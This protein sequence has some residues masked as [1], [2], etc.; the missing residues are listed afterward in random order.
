V[1]EFI[2]P[3]KFGHYERGGGRADGLP[4]QY[5]LAMIGV[6]PWDTLA[7]VGIMP[8]TRARPVPTCSRNGVPGI[9]RRQWLQTSCGLL[10]LP[11]S[12]FLGLRAAGEPP[13][14]SPGGRAKAC[15]IVYC[16]GG[17]SHLDTL[18]LKPDA[19]AEIR[20][21]FRP[22]ATRV[23]GIRISEHLPLLARHADKLALI[24]SIHHRSTAHGKGMYWNL[25]GHAPAQAEAAV[26]QP[27]SREDWPCLAAMIGQFR[28][29]ARGLPHAVQLP[30]PLVDNNTLQAGENAGWL[31]VAAD[32]VIVRTPRG[33]AFGGVS[34]DLGAPVLNLSSQDTDALQ[35]RR[36]LLARLDA[37][38]VRSPAEANLDHYRALA[39]DMLLNPAVRR[40]FDLD[41]EPPRLRDAYGDHLGGQ[42]LLLARRLVEAGVPVVTVICAAGD[43]NGSAGDHWDTHSD[44]FNRLK[45]T[46]LPVLDRGVAALLD[47]LH[48]RGRLEETL[49]VILG[50]F[51][52][53]PKVNGSAGRDHYPYAFSVALA[54]GG[55]R[56]GQVY[57]STDRHGAFPH[58]CPCG[59]NDLHATIF[60]SLGI[61]LDAILYDRLHRP[62]L[63]TD[64]R[65]LPLFG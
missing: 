14:R 25:T 59:P 50:D 35:A 51:G 52:R 58:S 37:H 2:R 23:P 41:Q 32:P 63:L 27:P 3:N 56:G 4:Q 12:S 15:I 5:Q 55:I 13:S 29:P 11:L 43:L 30:Y 19:P 64:G 39:L 8:V 53:T 17:M 22:I 7:V 20:G 49:V 65:P 33:K 31:G 18:D 26:N 28:A 45:N 61:P 36:G 21:Q 44:N 38:P 10:G 9:S 42:S 6:P 60:Q 47:D 34:R 24:R 1:A 48:Q 40:A 16:W 54:G 46:M 62:H 57:G